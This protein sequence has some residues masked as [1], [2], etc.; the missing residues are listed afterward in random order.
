MSQHSAN[1]AALPAVVAELAEACRRFVEQAVGVALDGTQDTLPLLDHYLKEVPQE[2]P[3]EVV[4]LV[5]P[6]AG[7]YFGEVVRNT[8]ADGNWHAPQNEYEAW[9]LSFNSCSLRFNP[10]AVASEVRAGAS[11]GGGLQLNPQEQK[12]AEAALARTQSVD[13]D[14]YYRLTVRFEAIE[15]VYLLLSGERA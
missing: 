10:V 5:V 7:A 15:Q 2:A 12:L 11:D 9:Q 3:A 13:P 8:L 14:D 6:A 1:G 4:D